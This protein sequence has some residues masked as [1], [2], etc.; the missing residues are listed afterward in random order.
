MLGPVVFHEKIDVV[1]LESFGA[2]CVATLQLRY[3]G[4]STKP[5]SEIRV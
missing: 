5:P 1:T 3:H 4:K 2:K